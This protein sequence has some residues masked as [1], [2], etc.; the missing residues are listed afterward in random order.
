[1]IAKMQTAES[2]LVY[3]YRAGILQG[4]CEY[5]LKLNK[6]VQSDIYI[7]T[8]S[9]RIAG[10]NIDYFLHRLMY[11]YLSERLIRLILLKY[12]S[13]RTEETTISHTNCLSLCSIRWY[14]LSLSHL[15]YL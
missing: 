7:N 12:R 9:E 11:K 13:M 3:K 2:T 5:S 15:Y 8:G 6:H 1:M 4:D 10:K 14:V